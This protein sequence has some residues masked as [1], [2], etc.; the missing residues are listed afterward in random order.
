MLKLK[1]L[2]ILPQKH[3]TS[4]TVSSFCRKK[5]SIRWNS[6]T[7]TNN[8]P[9][10][11]PVPETTASNETTTS[12]QQPVESKPKRTRRKKIIMEDI[13]EKTT[14]GDIEAPAPKLRHTRTYARDPRTHVVLVDGS[15]IFQ[16]NFY[17]LRKLFNGGLFGF[18]R[19]LMRVHND[20]SPIEHIGNLFISCC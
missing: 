14:M 3:T 1:T 12:T 20:L 13:A 19:Q 9:T 5:A 4:V 2:H 16:K 7:S 11:E 18:T 17:A 15:G 8:A 6:D 10:I